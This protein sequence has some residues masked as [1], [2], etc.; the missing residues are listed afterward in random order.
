MGLGLVCHSHPL[1]GEVA[2][3][4]EVSAHLMQTDGEK[5]KE[6]ERRGVNMRG[7]REVDRREGGIYILEYEDTLGIKIG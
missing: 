4:D 7:K 1:K 6:R 2:A 3:L 5:G